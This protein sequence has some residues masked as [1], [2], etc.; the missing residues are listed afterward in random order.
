MIVCAHADCKKH[1]RDRYGNQRYRCLLCGKTWIDRAPK[2]LGDMLL[3]HSRAVMCLKL[4]LEGASLRSI[5]RLTGVSRNT[6]AGLLL[7][8]GERCRLYWLAKMRKLPAKEV[9][10]DELW[11]FVGCK[12]K[13]RKVLDRSQDFGDAYCYLAIERETK[14]VLAYHVGKRDVWDTHEF[15]HKLRLATSGQFMVTTDGYTPYCIAVPENL[16]DRGIQ[17]AQLIKIFGKQGGS[18]E[19][20]YSPAPIKSIRK[21]AMW[22]N[23]DLDRA[24][25][26][27]CER[28]NL[29][30]RMSIRRLTRLTNGFSKSWRHHEAALALWLTWYNFGRVHMTLRTTPAVA[31]GIADSPWIVERMLDELATQV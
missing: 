11:G 2:P 24:C 9:Q 10:V 15:T 17:F 28:L 20:R 21:K 29:S 19:S 31:A 26:S 23:L 14:L 16:H 4:M 13:T 1:G 18:A 22:G 6:L 12:E 25:T 8:V 5:E 27:H 3:D 7:L 30:L